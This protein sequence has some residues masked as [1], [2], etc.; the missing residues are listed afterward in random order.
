MKDVEIGDMV[1][2]GS[3]GYSPIYGFGHRSTDQLAKYLVL[4]T[5]HR[6]AI[7]ISKDHLIFV[8]DLGAIPA[9]AV[10]VGTLLLSEDGTATAVTQISTINRVGAFAPFTSSGTI[11]VGGVLA[12]NYVTLQDQSEAFVVAGVK[13]VSMHELAHTFQAPRR[14]IC[15]V[16]PSLC[17]AE[18][19]TKDGISTWVYGPF[20]AAQWLLN[21]RGVVVTVLSVGV[22]AVA[23]LLYVAEMS[24]MN[25]PFL[26]AATFGVFSMMRSKKKF[27]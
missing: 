15:S 4:H 20:L 8:E 5:E 26:V 10:K 9:S 2:I 24:F 19:Y 13:V 7:E 17:M 14:M 18:A 22:L 11:V 27:A 21:Q 1:S 23:M 6:E 12:S 16:I 3:K 25:F